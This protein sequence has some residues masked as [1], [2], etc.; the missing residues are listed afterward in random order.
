MEQAFRVKQNP[1]LGSDDKD[2]ENRYIPSSP[3]GRMALGN[4]D[5]EGEDMMDLCS[6]PPQ[7]VTTIKSFD[8][9]GIRILLGS[10]NINSAWNFNLFNKSTSCVVVMRLFQ[11]WILLGTTR[12]PQ[13]RVRAP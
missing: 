13:L 4:E 5:E 6:S 3:L 10:R 1:H 2:N 8:G 9:V 7:S 12:F 11:V